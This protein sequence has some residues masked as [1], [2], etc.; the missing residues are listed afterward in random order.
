LKVVGSIK[1]L[2]GK[3]KKNGRVTGYAWF[4][5]HEMHEDGTAG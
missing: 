4:K 3:V 5:R 2:Q 1:V